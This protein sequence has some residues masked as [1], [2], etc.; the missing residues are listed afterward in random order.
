MPSLPAGAPDHHLRHRRSR[1]GKPQL[2]EAGI[3]AAALELIDEAGLEG[4]SFRTLAKR[5]GCEAMSLYHYF[6]S[7]AHLYDA[8]IAQCIAEMTMPAPELPWIERLRLLAHEFRNLALRHPGFYLYFGLYRMNSRPA[9][10]L[11]NTLLVTFEESGLDDEARARHFRATGYYLTGAGLEEAMGY[12]KGPSAAEPVPGDVIARDFPAIV[13]VGR[14]FG[15]DYRQ[16]TFEQ[17]LETLL[18][19]VAE[20]AG[21]RR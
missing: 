17:G 14:Y 13:R 16:A 1:A 15:P 18:A 4:F 5:L 10:Q 21:T 12:A 7:K 8:L 9:L 20:D 2:S 3:A 11:L 19:K 6:P